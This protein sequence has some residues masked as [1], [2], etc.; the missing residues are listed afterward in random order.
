M[1]NNNEPYK[2]QILLGEICSL[3]WAPFIVKVQKGTT[4]IRITEWPG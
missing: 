3:Y 4:T 1:K 2:A